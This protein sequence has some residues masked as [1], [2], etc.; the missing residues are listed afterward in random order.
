MIYLYTEIFDSTNEDYIYEN[1]KKNSWALI[2]NGV[3]ITELPTKKDLLLY[4]QCFFANEALVWLANRFEVPID[5][6]NLFY[7]LAGYATDKNKDSMFKISQQIL[8]NSAH[9]LIYFDTCNNKNN[10]EY[11]KLVEDFKLKYPDDFQ[12]RIFKYSKV[13]ADNKIQTQIIDKILLIVQT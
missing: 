10:E 3:I 2:K 12:D 11:V 6:P 5:I 1:P 4:R 9:I 7:T 13:I 8:K